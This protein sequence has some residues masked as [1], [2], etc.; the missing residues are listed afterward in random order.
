LAFVDADDR[1]L[2]RTLERSITILD[3]D[4]GC[5]LAYGNLLMVDS[6]GRS[7]ETYLISGDYAHAPSMGEILARMLPIMP[8]P[9]LIP[10]SA[11]DACGGFVEDFRG[12][13]FEDAFLWLRLRE[14]GH[15]CY[16]PQPLAAWRF[17][18]FPK[19][20]KVQPDRHD[21]DTFARLV[22]QR[23]EIDPSRLVAAR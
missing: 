13:G 14:Q 16:I 22:R 4:P 23:Y 15:F 2:P 21:R 12:A 10:P 9:P 3:S 7:L 17:S 19:S 11:F 1:W 6:E 20:L 8:T 18:W 5:A